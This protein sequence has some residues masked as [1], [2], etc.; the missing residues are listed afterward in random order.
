MKNSHTPL[1]VLNVALAM[2]ITSIA[3]PVKVNTFLQSVSTGEL[4][5]GFR[6]LAGVPVAVE[7]G[8]VKNLATQALSGGLEGQVTSLESGRPVAGARV[9]VAALG[10]ETTSGPDGR[11]AWGSIPMAEEIVP[12]TVQ[13]SAPGYGEWVLQDVTLFANDTLII[14]ARLG[15][16]RYHDI[17]PPP[18]AEEPEPPLQ[19]TPPEFST[20]PLARNHAGLPVPQYIRVRVSGYPYHCDTK[21][22]YRVD[23]VDFKQYVKHVLPNEWS[24]GWH[25]ESLRAGGMAVKMYAWSVIALAYKWPDADVWDSTCDQV[26]NPNFERASTNRAV[27]AIWDYVASVNGLLLHASYRAHYSQCISANKE[28]R[29]MGQW[30][31]KYMADEGYTWEEILLHFY[32]GSKVGLATRR[33]PQGY[34]LRYNGQSGD[35]K[36]NRVLIQVDDPATDE[37]GPPVDVGAADFTIDF[38]MKAMPGENQAPAINCGENENWI[39][40][41]ILLDRSRTSPGRQY[42]LSLAGG[43]LAFGVSGENGQARTLCGTAD[44]ADGK[45]RHISVQRRQA[46]GYLWMYVGGQLQAEG[47]GPPGDI[48]Y[49]D[50]AAPGVESDPYLGIGAWK[51]DTN[52]NQHQFFRG[53]I[54]DLRF[55]NVLRYGE[56]FNLPIMAYVSDEHTVALYNFDDGVGDLIFESSGYSGGASH[57]ARKYGGAVRGPEWMAAELFLPELLNQVFVPLVRR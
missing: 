52:Q 37:P 18:R 32:E 1:L 39:Y 57:G 49:P 43:R 14:N 23:V 30:D 8:S 11:F 3:P 50:G 7:A 25:Q 28:G 5:A 34:Q 44:L 46:D 51:R 6:Q 10:L 24:A 2:L 15:E 53:Y 45:W 56:E 9:N 35:L 26:Y 54:N 17:V 21:R 12:I 27:D 38:W 36:T 31:S 20:I 48:S 16:E 22:P 55:S 40:G 13:V 29:C 19:D 41:N 47:S 4:A 42:G 33:P